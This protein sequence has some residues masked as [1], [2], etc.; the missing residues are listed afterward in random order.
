MLDGLASVLKPFADFTKLIQGVNYPTINLVP[1]L[2]TEIEYG[3]E[4][5]RL[6][7]NDELIIGAVDILLSN[8]RKR[9]ELSDVVVAAG[10]LD[11]AVQH[12][13]IIDSWL[14]EKGEVH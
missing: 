1:L 2:I 14:C 11:P 8:I 7:S 5:L 9:I 3:L 13:S 10:C 6:F 4:N 12:L